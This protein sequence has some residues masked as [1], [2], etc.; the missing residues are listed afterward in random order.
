MSFE[1]DLT[2]AT[3]ALNDAAEAYHGKITEIDGRVDQAEG[4]YAA[5]A[6]SLKGVVNAQMAFS[7]TVDPDNPAPTNID[8]GTF[9]TIKA[10]VDAAPAGAFVTCYLISD[11][12]YT[13]SQNIGFTNQ[14][15]F[16]RK[17]GGGADPI[18]DV[19]AFE[20]DAHNNIYA[21]VPYGV[22]G[23]KFHDIDLRLPTAEPNPAKPW[24][25]ARS[26]VQY[27]VGMPIAVALSA[28]TVTGG[29]AGV[30][31]GVM[32]NNG[33]GTSFFAMWVSTLD[34]PIFGVVDAGTGVTTVA[35]SAATF[36][37]GAAATT[38]A[39]LGANLLEN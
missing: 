11:K 20:T 23:V 7:G 39:T 34:G 12:T 16:F 19:P 22:C 10:L 25:S 33:A 29:I 17:S 1:D 9:N 5:L 8:G 36:A 6:V 32:S 38:T 3:Q 26:I 13:L 24:S 14:F 15:L 30:N 31:L 37:N 27:Q 18:L 4:E 35:K 21:F 2:A 28:S